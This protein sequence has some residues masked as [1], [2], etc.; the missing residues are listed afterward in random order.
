MSLNGLPS[1]YGGNEIDTYR[2]NG[3]T[4]E[5]DS[6]GSGEPGEGEDGTLQTAYTQ[7][8]SRS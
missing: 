1:H 5:S 4:F 6:V 3:D 8:T 2:S 7:A